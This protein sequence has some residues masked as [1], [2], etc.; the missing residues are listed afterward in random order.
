ML[1]ALK[2][3]RIINKFG[4]RFKFTA[5][6]QHRIRELMAGARPLVERNGRNDFEVAVQEIVENKISL[7]LPVEEED[8][9]AEA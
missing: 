7:Q 2:D 8:Q 1:D 6:V 3:D 9:D 4:G 5:L